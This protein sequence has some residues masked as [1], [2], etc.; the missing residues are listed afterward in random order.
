MM[1]VPDNFLGLEPRHSDPA[2]ARY[3]VLPV[4]YE[5]TVTYEP[6]TA[7]GPAAIIK[8]SRQVEL[9]DEELGREF[10]EAGVA[11]C[12]PV[13]PADDPAETRTAGDYDGRSITSDAVHQTQPARSRETEG[14]LR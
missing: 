12:P 9:F 1:N 5:G 13:D 4:P 7:A 10:F 14:A 6:G 8:A 2:T 3:A 11:T